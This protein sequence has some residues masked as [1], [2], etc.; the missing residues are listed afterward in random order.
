MWSLGQ[1]HWACYLKMFSLRLSWLQTTGSYLCFFFG[2]FTPLPNGSPT[3]VSP[4]THFF[5]FF[6]GILQ[7][8]CHPW[9][10]GK[11]MSCIVV[12]HICEHSNF[13]SRM[14]FSKIIGRT[15][16][17]GVKQQMKLF[18]SPIY[19]H[20][21]AIVETKWPI[22]AFVLYV[23]VSLYCYDALRCKRWRCFTQ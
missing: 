4:P 16:M 17:F 5:F 15:T 7:L 9:V 18:N 14:N 21:S 3:L 1:S 13:P 2:F 20:D 12:Q 22:R 10:R 6:L 8:L 19:F 11:S 23:L